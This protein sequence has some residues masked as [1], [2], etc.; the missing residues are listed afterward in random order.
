MQTITKHVSKFNISGFNW[1]RPER[2]DDA[3]RHRNG[4]GAGNFQKPNR[5]PIFQWT[6]SK[7]KKTNRKPIFQQTNSVEQEN[8]SSCAHKP[9]NSLFVSKKLPGA[10]PYLGISLKISHLH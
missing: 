6:N 7:L 4:P 3:R 10:S 9:S 5:K 8:S 1:M 2:E